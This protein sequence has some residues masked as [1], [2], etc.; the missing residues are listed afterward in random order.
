M[1]QDGR[2]RDGTGG[3][4]PHRQVKF[5]QEAR[6]GDPAS[7]PVEPPGAWAA[8]RRQPAPNPRAHTAGPAPAP[9]CACRRPGMA[10]TRRCSP[11]L[12]SCWPATR[13]SSSSAM[14]ATP[15]CRPTPPGT[16]ASSLR[17]G[18]GAGD[19][20]GSS[21]ALA[22]V[23]QHRRRL[24][25]GGCGQQA[26]ALPLLCLRLLF[27]CRPNPARPYPRRLSPP[28]TPPQVP[29]TAEQLQPV[30]NIVPLQLLAYH[31]TVLR[32]LNVDQPRN[33][34][35]SVTVTD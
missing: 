13:G 16:A 7:R 18:A 12:S 5:G 24:A 26:A 28:L 31:I 23:S 34:A 4:L 8:S 1:G 20:R 25:D 22:G 10:P 30:V 3:A 2:G 11:S 17:W 27:H 32:G 15:P 29:Q 14:R 35:K 33:L 19:G 21:D 6:A 9:L